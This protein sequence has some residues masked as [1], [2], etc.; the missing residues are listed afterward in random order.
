MKERAI[1]CAGYVRDTSW[2][3]GHSLSVEEQK[4]YIREAVVDKPDRE[5]VEIYEDHGNSHENLNK[6]IKSGLEG[7]FDCIL[8]QSIYFAAGI[9]PVLTQKIEDT[10]YPAGIR[11]IAIAE[12]VDSLDTDIHVWFDTLRR[13][14]HCDVTRSWKE[15]IGCQVE[16]YSLCG[17][18]KDNPPVVCCLQ[19]GKAM[20]IADGKYTCPHHTVEVG[21]I[22]TAVMDYISAERSLAAE[23][24]ER[25]KLGEYEKERQAQT[26]LL[27][28]EMKKAVAEAELDNLQRLPLYQS[29]RNGVISEEEYVIKVEAM[30][31]DY[32]ELDKK[33]DVLMK[34]QAEAEKGYS[35]KNPWLTQYLSDKKFLG[36]DRE[37]MRLNTER[38]EYDGETVSMT[39]R[40]EKWKR[41]LAE[42]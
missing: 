28:T 15:S 13:K 16:S 37:N 12:D 29:F 33:I 31:D 20:K 6:M 22:E 36:S 32:R 9:F 21:E 24:E 39:S 34:R 5:L 26:A 8:F 1:R 14:R 3:K 18:R 11:F 7:K 40:Q 41:M 35:L 4:S 2:K 27:K 25:V 23:L 30:R 17:R 38:I 42:N 10:L 19:C